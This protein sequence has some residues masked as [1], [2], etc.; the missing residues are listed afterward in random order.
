MVVLLPLL[1]ADPD[2]PPL[3]S[4]PAILAHMVWLPPHVDDADDHR[5]SIR[6][7]H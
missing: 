3:S 2:D 5:K 4:L 6:P 1:E 7:D